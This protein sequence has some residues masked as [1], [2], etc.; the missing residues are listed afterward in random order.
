MKVRFSEPQFSNFPIIAILDSPTTLKFLTHKRPAMVV[1]WVSMSVGNCLSSMTFLTIFCT[2]QC[3][4]N[5]HTSHING[6]YVAIMLTKGHFSHGEGLSINHHACLMLVT[7]ELKIE[8]LLL[9]TNP[10]YCQDGE[11]KMWPKMEHTDLE[12]GVGSLLSIKCVGLQTASKD[13][14]APN[15]NHTRASSTE[16]GFV[17]GVPGN[18]KTQPRHNE[19]ECQTL[20]AYKPPRSYFPSRVPGNML[21]CAQIVGR[22]QSD[23]FFFNIAPH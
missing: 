23:L 18:I 21:G 14:S 4:C 20:T 16:S 10:L 8:N 12:S 17:P 15:Q 2:I 9:A 1:F 11:A 7:K 3:S 5:Y 19:R 22:L 6:L 13:S